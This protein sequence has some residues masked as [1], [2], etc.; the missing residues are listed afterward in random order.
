M[1]MGSRWRKE[2]KQTTKE[3][4]YETV[5]N[6]T[7]THTHIQNNKDIREREWKDSKRREPNGEPRKLCMKLCS[8]EEKIAH[9]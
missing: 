3:V 7:H 9:K 8:E 6:R 4:T 2:A 5:L 1:R